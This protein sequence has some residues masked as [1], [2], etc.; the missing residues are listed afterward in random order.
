MARGAIERREDGE[1]ILLGSPPEARDA[2]PVRFER[3]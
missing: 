2:E 3:A 1:W